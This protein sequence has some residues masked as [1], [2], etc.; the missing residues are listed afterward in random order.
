MTG[1]AKRPLN[2]GTIP[3]PATLRIIAHVEKWTSLHPED[4]YRTLQQLRDAGEMEKLGLMLGM[5]GFVWTAKV[6]ELRVIY[7]G[8]A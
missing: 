2:Y 6:P 3:L 5:L 7:G 4:V 8:R 1:P